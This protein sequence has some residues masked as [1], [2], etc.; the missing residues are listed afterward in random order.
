MQKQ[1][2]LTQ[3][4][5]LTDSLKSLATAYEQIS[6][7]K[8]QEIRGSVVQTRTFLSG[9][10]AVYYKVRSSYRGKIQQLLD[11][12]R[13][14]NKVTA[15][16]KF[17]K[18]GKNALVLLSA[19]NKLYGD[20]IPKTINLFLQKIED[21]DGDII[22]VGKVGKDL[23]ENQNGEIPYTYF[24]VPDTSFKLDDLRPLLT[25]LLPYEKVTIFHGQ[26]DNVLNQFPKEAVITGQPLLE[27]EKQTQ[28]V[29][30]SLFEPSI[31]TI[32]AFF[33]TQIFSTLIKQTVHEGQLARFASR[34]RAMELALDNIATRRG[35]L[36]NTARQQR[37]LLA[38]KKQQ[39]QLAGIKLWKR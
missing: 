19:N 4:L 15:D 36:K 27:E 18:N 7:M 21:S 31:E 39:G 22:I 28:E 23:F 5:E 24:D 2:Q 12:E 29:F 38:N 13:K 1:S 37:N 35:E 33:E 17:K 6:V 10:S 8:M 9:L 34:I 14:K 30:K 25:F 32:L 11:Q 20:I 16:A 3:E 26:F